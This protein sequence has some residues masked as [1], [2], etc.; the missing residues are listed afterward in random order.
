MSEQET[1]KTKVEV[2]PEIRRER[3]KAWELANPD[4]V[5][6][7][8]RKGVLQT[9]LK[10]ASLPSKA[11]VDRYKFTKDEL[12]PIYEALHADR[13]GSVCCA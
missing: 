12:D 5:A 7:Y 8:R 10:R 13:C 1:K 2:T 9:C 6:S 3:K 11:T 4:K